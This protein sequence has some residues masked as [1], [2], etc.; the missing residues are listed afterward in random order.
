MQV[1]SSITSNLDVNFPL[2]QKFLLKPFISK[3]NIPVLQGNNHI[4]L[5]FYTDVFNIHVRLFLLNLNL[6]VSNHDAVSY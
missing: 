6:G 4:F 3:I 1:L 2:Q 5:S